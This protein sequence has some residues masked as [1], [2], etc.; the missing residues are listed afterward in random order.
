MN[1]TIKSTFPTFVGTNFKS[2][3][4][5]MIAANLDFKFHG[6]MNGVKIYSHWSIPKGTIYAYSNDST[7][8]VV[9][10]GNPE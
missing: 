8:E 3:I 5:D 4:A 9:N 1:D 2:R 10:V 6:T 7:I